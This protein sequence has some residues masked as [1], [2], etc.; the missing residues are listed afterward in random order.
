[1]FE[2]IDGDYA[3]VLLE[4]GSPTHSYPYEV[5]LHH[6]GS[7]WQELS[8][9]NGSGWHELPDGRSVVTSWDA[10]DSNCKLAY[11]SFCGQEFNAPLVSGYYFIAIWDP[12]CPAESHERDVPRLVT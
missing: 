9:S 2:S 5:L 12:A 1:L 10:V 3:V 7:S 4:T 11:V 6:P 8:S